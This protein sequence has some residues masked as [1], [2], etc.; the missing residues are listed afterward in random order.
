MMIL[1]NGC[2]LAVVTC[3]LA[4]ALSAQIA[5]ARIIGPTEEDKA[6]QQQQPQQQQPQQQ[7]PARPPQP[8]APAA[9]PAPPTQAAP[10]SSGI[11]L[12]E[13]GGFLLNNV[14]LTEMIDILAKMMKIN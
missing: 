8:G 4:S 2:K 7:Q 6:K 10:P 12:T 1:R 5:P 13:N 14:S 3:A 11:R 9:A